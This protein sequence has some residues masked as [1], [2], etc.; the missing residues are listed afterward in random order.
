VVKRDDLHDSHMLLLGDRGCGKRSLVKEIND[1]LVLG[2]NKKIGVDKM[3]SDFSALDFSFVYVKDLM[4][5]EN[6]RATVTVDD[7]L[8]KLNIW[9]LHDSTKGELLEA[10]ID[11]NDL[12]RTV[13]VIM[14][15]LENPLKIMESLREWLLSLGKTLT[16][17][18][19]N[20]KQGSYDKMK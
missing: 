1:K 7:N 4:D 15:D 19:P 3:G 12:E 9:S 16:N 13:A 17:I 18:F 5:T 14:L 6:I 10:V 2:R 8:P 11:P 20:M